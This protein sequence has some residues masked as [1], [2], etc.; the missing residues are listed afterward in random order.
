MGEIEDAVADFIVNHFEDEFEKVENLEDEVKNLK[1][2]VGDLSDK[3]DQL[4]DERQ[5]SDSEQEEEGS[6]E[7]E[8]K[9][10]RVSAS[11]LTSM[12]DRFDLTQKEL[13]DLLEV[14]SASITSWETGK[15]SP[16]KKNKA[17]IVELR[18]KSKGEV[19]ELLDRGEDSSDS[20]AEEIR[21]IRKE[22]GLNQSEFAE[23]VG[24]SPTTVSNW[25]TGSTTPSSDRL[26]EIRNLDIEETEEEERDQISGAYIKK[27]RNELGLSQ[28]EFAE[29]L[30]VS[31]TTVSN[32][33][34]GST[35][36]NSDLLD[37]VENLDVVEESEKESEDVE[38]SSEDIKQLREK[39]DLT[40]AEF[41]EEL[42]VSS[43]TVSNWERGASSP[44]KTAV[45]KLRKL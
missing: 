39:H 30:G 2:Q 5:V 4:L 10:T 20:A 32:W 23:Q 1:S 29:Q 28:K 26:E 27:V 9:Q 35:S 12:R 43:A 11:T 18:D 37:K 13:A 41:A 22:H 17:K 8:T 38:F 42:G 34:T 21:S 16:G 3:I 7:V 44:G 31:P 19:D 45:E 6:D 14:S 33:E 15:T 25:E 40:Q 36:P 24:V